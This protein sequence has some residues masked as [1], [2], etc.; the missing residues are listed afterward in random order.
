MYTT[1]TK[2]ISIFFEIRVKCFVLEISYSFFFFKSSIYY[3][4][5]VGRPWQHYVKGSY[6]PPAHVV[7][8]SPRPQL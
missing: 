4:E 5:H 8:V 7:S 3:T 2:V 1:A 6:T